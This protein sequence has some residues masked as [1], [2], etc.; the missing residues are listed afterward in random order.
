MKLLNDV[1]TLI[2]D[3][4]QKS[5]SVWFR[6]QGSASW[7]LLSSLH[8]SINKTVDEAKAIS[9]KL[10]NQD[11]TPMFHAMQKTLYLKFK[12]RSVDFTPAHWRKDWELLFTM[13]HFGIP[14]RL[15]DWTKSFACALHFAVKDWKDNDDAA[16]FILYPELLN[17]HSTKNLSLLMLEGNIDKPSSLNIANY[18]PNALNKKGDS[19]T[20][21]IEPPLINSRMIAQNAVFTLCGSD[22]TSLENKYKDCIIK[23]TLNKNI[24]DEVNKFIS[25]LGLNDFS[26]F[27]DLEGLK[28]F[29]NHEIQIEE[30]R[31]L[32]ALRSQI[33]R[34]EN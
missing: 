2:D 32:K 6:G 19:E 23:L 29:M 7:P 13:Q 16:I 22:F 34:I 8:R 26:Y 30:A 4:N 20:I 28:K 27:P 3:A 25:T 10:I 12:M 17:L 9:S 5:Y 15:L 18:H 31:I 21:A 24:R 33:T 1:A 11:L 14:T